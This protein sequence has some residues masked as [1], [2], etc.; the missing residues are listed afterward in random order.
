MGLLQKKTWLKCWISEFSFLSSCRFTAGWWMPQSV[1]LWLH[2]Q[3]LFLLQSRGRFYAPW[4]LPEFWIHLQLSHFRTFL[5]G[6]AANCHR[7]A[8]TTYLGEF[9]ERSDCD[10]TIIRIQANI[11]SWKWWLF[12]GSCLVCFF[13]Q[14]LSHCSH[15]P[16][17]FV[18]AQFWRYRLWWVV[19]FFIYV[20]IY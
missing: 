4:G 18:R 3:P 15:L 9:S 6:L 14:W 2:V 17:W 13:F 12:R 16:L 8:E 11:K 7:T 20:C 10:R 19:H 1:K 5:R